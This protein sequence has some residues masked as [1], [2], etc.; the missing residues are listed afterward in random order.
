MTL[1][2][3]NKVAKRL[4]KW[5]KDH[6]PGL[7]HWRVLDRQSEPKGQVYPSYRPGLP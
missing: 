1:R 7:Q 3:K 2:T 6:D 4:L 5:I